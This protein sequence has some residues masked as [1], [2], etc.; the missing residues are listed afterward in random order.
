[1]TVKAGVNLRYNKVT[2]TS[3][4]SSSIN[5]S[6][7]LSDVADFAS[8]IVNGT[9]QGSRFSQSYPLLQAAHIRVASLDFYLADDWNVSKKIKLQYGLRF[10][11]DRNPA[12]ADNCFSHMSTE[13]LAQ[14][15]QAGANVPYNATIQTGLGTAYAK[16]EGFMVEPRFGIVYSPFASH[17]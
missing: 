6:Y 17:K 8:G 15:Y 12:C 4:A 5:G 9:N 1:H 7:S 16:Y 10:E 13:F 11:K 14:G 3:I 2:D